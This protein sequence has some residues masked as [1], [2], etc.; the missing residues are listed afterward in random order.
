[1]APVRE[2]RETTT[3]YGAQPSTLENDHQ[4]WCSVNNTSACTSPTAK[5]RLI[6]CGGPLVMLKGGAR[7]EN[8]FAKSKF[9][10][11]HKTH[12]LRAKIDF[13]GGF[14]QRKV[15]KGPCPFNKRARGSPFGRPPPTGAFRGV[16]RPLFLAKF[17]F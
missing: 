6:F 8:P 1:M 2:K 17:H 4:I 5:S 13:G 15:A 14:E 3:Q 11:K 16:R 10:C 12:F 9:I 7:C